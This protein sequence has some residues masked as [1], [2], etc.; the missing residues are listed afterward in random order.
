MDLSDLDQN[1]YY[2]YPKQNLLGKDMF[3]TFIFMI[4]TFVVITMYGTNKNSELNDMHKELEEKL[5]KIDTLEK[6]IFEKETELDDCRAKVKDLE[7]K[8]KFLTMQNENNIQLLDVKEKLINKL[9]NRHEVLYESFGEYLQNKK[10]TYNL[11]K[12]RKVDYKIDIDTDTES[13]DSD[14]L[15]HSG[16]EK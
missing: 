14:Y 1:N 10:C 3:Y 13:D 9:K 5:Q 12:R 11:R 7:D 6:S 2:E 8:N 4:V 15:P 16:D